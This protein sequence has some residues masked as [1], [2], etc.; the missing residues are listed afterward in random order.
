MCYSPQVTLGVTTTRGSGKGMG[1]GTAE[2]RGQKGVIDQFKH[3]LGQAYSLG[4]SLVVSQ[5]L[6]IKLL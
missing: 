5:K 6:S 1:H 2:K 4:N 3:G